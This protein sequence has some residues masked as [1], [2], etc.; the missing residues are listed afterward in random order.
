MDF[1]SFII[2]VIVGIILCQLGYYEIGK[3]KVAEWANKE[4]NENVHP[5]F[6]L[7]P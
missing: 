4:L 3:K 6:S 5:N 2:G 1:K 7:Q